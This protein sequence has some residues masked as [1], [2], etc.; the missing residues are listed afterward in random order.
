MSSFD[1]E[2][3]KADV[4]PPE[5]PQPEVPLPA[6][7]T[8]ITPQ[9]RKGRFNIFAAKSFLI[10]VSEQTIAQLNLSVGDEVDETLFKNIF[11][12]EYRNKLKNYLLELLG[13]REYSRLELYRK[14][15]NKGYD[16]KLANQILDEME[17]NEYLSDRRFTKAYVRD[18][19]NFNRWGPRKIRA[20][21]MKKGIK[22]DLASEIIDKV[23]GR[24]EQL[25][26]AVAL[27]EKRKA[28][29][30]RESDPAK[31]REKM[32]RYLAGRGY[33]SQICYQAVSKVLG[34][35]GRSPFG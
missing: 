6:D 11:R 18:K 23:I 35:G 3:P 7:I 12:L 22:S 19:H 31:K 5:M 21:L 14:A 17:Q 10:G 28:R 2:E 9:K 27:L 8:S 30:E 29:Y 26:H 25:D 34:E 1:R 32:L 16:Q 20:G 4:Q 24:D 33:P 15:R 13:R